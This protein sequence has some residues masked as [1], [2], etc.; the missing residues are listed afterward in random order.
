MRVT[1]ANWVIEGENGWEENNQLLTEAHYVRSVLGGARKSLSW[2]GHGGPLAG[3][4][5][6]LAQRVFA[7]VQPV[8]NDLELYSTNVVFR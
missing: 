6:E 3:N 4:L 5:N 8:T 2:S 7:T 1:G